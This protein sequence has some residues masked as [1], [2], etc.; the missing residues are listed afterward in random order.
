MEPQTQRVDEGTRAAADPG[1]GGVPGTQCPADA[2]RRLDLN[3]GMFLPHED[4][5]SNESISHICRASQ[6]THA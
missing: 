2:E 1:V 5:T 4:L 6:G 3:N